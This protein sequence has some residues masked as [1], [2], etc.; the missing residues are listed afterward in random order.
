MKSGTK[1][2]VGILAV[3]AVTF[4]WFFGTRNNLVSLKESIEMQ[5]SQIETDLQH[6]MDLIPNLVATVQG[7]A[8]HEKEV[9]TAIAYARKSL[10]NSINSGNIEDISKANDS[11]DS[12]LGGLLAISENYPTLQAS[13]QFTALQDEL[14]GSENR[15]ATSR[16]YYNEAVQ[17][18]NTAIQRFPTSLIAGMSGYYPAPYFK[19]DVEALKVPKVNFD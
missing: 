1:V 8:D 15:I 18:Y 7:Y 12:A 14:A 6:R 19:A 17:V 10:L 4:F 3:L 2:L 13:E 9:F 16:K 5:Q 11:L